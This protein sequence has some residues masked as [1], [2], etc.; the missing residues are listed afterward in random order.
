MSLKYHSHRWQKPS[1]RK[2]RDDEMVLG[3][4]V[5]KLKKTGKPEVV[6]YAICFFMEDG[7][8]AIRDSEDFIVGIQ[9]PPDFWRYIDSPIRQR[10]PMGSKQKA[11]ISKAM[12]RVWAER[13]A[14]GGNA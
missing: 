8:W 13:K 1:K 5:S 9:D 7:T 2:P 4:W 10:G 14:K 3:A 6:D 12:L 11:A